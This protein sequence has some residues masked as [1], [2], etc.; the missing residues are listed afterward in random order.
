MENTQQ[1]QQEDGDKIDVVF[2]SGSITA[3]GILVGF[4][5]NFAS[6]WVS[7]PGTWST[8]DFLAIAPLLLGII[9]Q[10]RALASLLSVSSIYVVHY[11]RAKTTFLIGLLLAAI[12][13]IV[14]LGVDIGTVQGFRPGG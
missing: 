1:T 14:A 3:V 5:L 13:I 7:S 9:L 8:Y 6:Q 2:R 4:S 10:V 12:G 11:N